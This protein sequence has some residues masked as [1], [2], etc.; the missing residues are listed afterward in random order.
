MEVSYEMARRLVVMLPIRY[1]ETVQ[2]RICRAGRRGC[3]HPH[4]SYR[5]GYLYPAVSLHFWKREIGQ[6]KYG[7]WSPFYQN[8]WHIPRIIGLY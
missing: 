7:R 4:P 6:A 8:L 5:F 3:K 2:R 1:P